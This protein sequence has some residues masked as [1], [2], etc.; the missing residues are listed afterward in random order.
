MARMVFTRHVPGSLAAIYSRVTPQQASQHPLYRQFVRC[1]AHGCHAGVGGMQDHLPGLLFD[2]FQGRFLVVD[3]CDNDIAVY[4]AVLLFDDDVVAIQY[5]LLDHR[6]TAHLQNITR[7]VAQQ[8]VWH[9][10]ELGL[11]NGLDGTASGNRA[12][13][14]DARRR[15][16]LFDQANSAAIA[17]HGLDQAGL[18]EGLDVFVQRA[19]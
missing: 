4:G 2:A 16:F 6:V 10:H 7:L 11:R 19:A 3:Q 12:Q 17:V 15:C 8:F 1:I 5:S 13:Q 9:L 18:D 14:G